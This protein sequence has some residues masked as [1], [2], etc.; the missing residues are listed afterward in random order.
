MQLHL[1]EMLN[2]GALAHSIYNNL[3]RTWSHQ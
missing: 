1:P 3:L 2:G